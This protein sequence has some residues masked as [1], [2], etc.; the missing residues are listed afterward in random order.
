MS[1][2]GATHTLAP[3]ALVIDAEMARSENSL[4]GA[5]APQA[6]GIADRR[7]FTLGVFAGLATV[8]AAFWSIAAVLIVTSL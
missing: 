8:C 4:E 3:A 6:L 2:H 5:G 1:V 7:W